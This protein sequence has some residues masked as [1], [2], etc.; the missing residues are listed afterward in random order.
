[1]RELESTA[2]YR[3]E[4]GVNLV[5]K[6]QKVTRQENPQQLSDPPEIMT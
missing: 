1:V 3:L 6:S 5:E 2:T 4:V